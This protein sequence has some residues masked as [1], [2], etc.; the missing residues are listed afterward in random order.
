VVGYL[1]IVAAIKLVV[2]TRALP[3]NLDSPESFAFVV[4]MPLVATFT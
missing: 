1:V 3:I 4:M 2:L